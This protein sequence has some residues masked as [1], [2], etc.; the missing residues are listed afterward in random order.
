MRFRSPPVGIL[1]LV[2][3]AVL[4]TAVC[5]S[6]N[7]PDEVGPIGGVIIGWLF[8]TGLVCGGFFDDWLP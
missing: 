3:V 8:M 1:L 7:L 2:V 5:V 4:W 6:T